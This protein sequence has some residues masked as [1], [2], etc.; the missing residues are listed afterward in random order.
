[1]GRITSI[2][3][4][5]YSHFSQSY[6][7][8]AKSWSEALT[9]SRASD[10]FIIVDYGATWCKPCKQLDKLF[11]DSDIIKLIDT[12]YV[13]LKMQ[14][15]TTTKDSKSTKSM[16]L[17]SRMFKDSFEI[18]SYPTLLFFSSEG[19]ILHKE[20]GLKQKRNW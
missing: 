14:A 9:K 19:T 13:L 16:Y 15:D 18:R 3:F 20:V 12:N 4:F 8:K 7:F 10:K 11:L 6:T 2:G 17:T 5:T 1:M